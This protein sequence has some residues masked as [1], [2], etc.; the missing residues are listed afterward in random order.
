M[1]NILI[2]TS[3]GGGGLL[4]TANAMQQRVLVENP[5]TRIIRCDILKDWFWAGIGKYWGNQW[6]HAQRK[7]DVSTL[8]WIVN[9][10]IFA[11]YLFWPAIFFQSLRTLFR[12]QI[13][14]V[15]D[16][17]PMGTSALLKA[18]RI[19]NWV[20]AKNIQLEKIVV[21]LPT[22]DATHFFGPVKKLSP[23]D[24][25]T[26]KLTTIPP[27]LSPGETDEAFWQHHCNLTPSAICFEKFY[28]RQ[29]F[30]KYQKKECLAEPFSIQIRIKNQEERTLIQ[31]SVEKGVLRPLY[32]DQNITFSIPPKDRLATLLLGSQPA[33]DATLRYVMRFIQEAQRKDP[34]G[35]PLHLF[36]F[37]ADHQPGEESLFRTISLRVSKEM[38][39]PSQLSIIP[40]SFQEEDVIAP[41]FS[42][43]NLT[44]TRSGGQTAMELMCVSSGK[45]WIHSEARIDP[46]TGALPTREALLAGIP[47][48]EAG[49]ARY[50]ENR[51]GAQ[52]VTP[53][54][55]SVAEWFA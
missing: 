2:I 45:T 47:G 36:V 4:Q 35:L 16:T 10:Q 21:D 32:Q 19:Y 49:N 37:C 24:R 14:R 31:K 18:I 30:L 44:C 34:A 11:D 52:I 15:I 12:E 6:N 20:K 23:L 1:H 5:N 7:G 27:L 28:V 43:S 33:N 39:Y 48:W 42:R 55:S 22:E 54:T 29:T 25:S 40:I 51:L 38:N 26:L 41:L 50:L 9:W 13:D 53:E 8:S 17:Q 46:R 3:S